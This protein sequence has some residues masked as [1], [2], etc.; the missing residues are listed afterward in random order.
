M[1]PTT[2]TAVPCVQPQATPPH[3]Q[4]PNL[5]PSPRTRNICLFLNSPEMKI[6]LPNGTSPQQATA[7]VEV[8]DWINNV[9]TYQSRVAAIDVVFQWLQLALTVAHKSSTV[10]QF[11]RSLLSLNSFTL[12][13]KYMKIWEPL[14]SFCREKLRALGNVIK[15][16]CREEQYHQ[17]L[18]EHG[19]IDMHPQ[20]LIE[21]GG[22]DEFRQD[23]IVCDL[24]PV[25]IEYDTFYGG[26][27]VHL[28]FL[29]LLGVLLNDT[30][31]QRVQR[32]LIGINGTKHR[33]API[34]R[35]SKL[36]SQIFKPEPLGDRYKV[37]PRGAHALDVMR[38]SVTFKD[39]ASLKLGVA[40]LVLEFGCD[41]DGN[42]NVGGIGSIHN[43]FSASEREASNRF[44]SRSIELYVIVDFGMTFYELSQKSDT[45]V[46]DY[47]HA[48]PEAGSKEPWGRWRREAMQAAEILRSD[49]M[50][51]KRVRMVCEIVVS[52]TLFEENRVETVL[53]KQILDA[54]TPLMLHQSFVMHATKESSS[55]AVTEAEEEQAY[56]RTIIQLNNAR[57]LDADANLI[58]CGRLLHQTVREGFAKAVRI[59]LDIEKEVED[60]DEEKEENEKEKMLLEEENRNGMDEVFPKVNI[61]QVDGKGRTPLSVASRCGHLD[62]V[63]IL[64]NQ[65]E[66]EGNV[67][68]NDGRTALFHAVSAGHSNVVSALINQ[69]ETR[70]DV[71]AVNDEGETPLYVACDQGHFDCVCLLLSARSV[72]VNVSK[73]SG[74]TPLFVACERGHTD[75]VRVLLKKRD[76]KT[77]IAKDNGSTPL[78]AACMYQ[79]L[80]TITA[81]L[82]TKGT[83]S[84]VCLRDGVTA[85]HRACDLGHFDVVALLLRARKI[86]INQCTRKG[87]TPV[88]IASRRGFDDVIRLLLRC[89]GVAVTKKD[90]QGLSAIDYARKERHDSILQH[91]DDYRKFGPKHLR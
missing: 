26:E 7:P 53:M 63:G 49:D 12:T 27:S 1:I 37:A 77:N 75:V 90:D 43:R 67:I 39:P 52:L 14:Q 73:N 22:D 34:K 32:A 71:N 91:L 18:G 36:R 74:A 62:V 54:K 31:Q 78:F 11:V 6:V 15:F 89:R 82:S 48:L 80:D 76:I 4:R 85:L 40:Q 56:E 35:Y 55:G 3:K 9:G 42:G 45:I 21:G 59:V 47:T 79:H 87:S 16:K 41:K 64:L 8:H 61:N 28:H 57:E 25:G 58:E 60:D 23:H 68:D 65:T 46:R 29:R 84:N 72:L 19:W 88:S 50:G 83:K 10:D 24:A 51:D 30:F 70:V 81:L 33:G 38:C 44:H 66:T 17:L 86:D 5:Q 13:M 20:V 2:T 69:I